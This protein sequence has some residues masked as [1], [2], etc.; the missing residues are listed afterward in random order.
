MLPITI[1]S[2]DPCRGWQAGLVWVFFQS[3]ILMIGGYHRKIIDPWV[4][5]RAPCSARVAASPAFI[6][7]RPALAW[8]CR[9][10]SALT[11]FAI[12]W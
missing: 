4:T 1:T 12:P 7:I 9:T 10:R 3:F 6:S 8:R 5:P 2:G 11:C